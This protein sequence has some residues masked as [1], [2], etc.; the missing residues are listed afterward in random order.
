MLPRMMDHA[1]GD[2]IKRWC[3]AKGV[4]V[5]TSTKVTGIEEA[6]KALKISYGDGS[7]AEVDLV[8]SG[9][10]ADLAALAALD[11]PV[12]R[13]RYEFAETE[14]PGLGAIVDRWL[15]DAKVA[16]AAP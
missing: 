8:V 5:L 16:G 15:E 10:P 9:T 3:E 1:G 2:M 4:K 6:G 11:K 14:E 7:S 13:A 12:A